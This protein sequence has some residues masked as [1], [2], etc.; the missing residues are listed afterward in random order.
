MDNHKSEYLNE[1][2]SKEVILFV[3]IKIIGG[4]L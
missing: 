4:A 2:L 3:H 1:Y